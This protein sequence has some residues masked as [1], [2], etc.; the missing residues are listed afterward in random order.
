MLFYFLVFSIVSGDNNFYR[1]LINEAKANISTR[2]LHDFDS[3]EESKS[4]GFYSLDN[5]RVSFRLIKTLTSPKTI[6]IV[7]YSLKEQHLALITTSKS[8]LD[9]NQPVV[10]IEPSSQKLYQLSNSLYSEKNSNSDF[11]SDVFKITPIDVLSVFTDI[12]IE[13]EFRTDFSDDSMSLS[14][15]INVNWD[16]GKDQPHLLS[17]QSIGIGGKIEAVAKVTF[18]FGFI[19]STSLTL[20]FSLSGEVGALL[21]LRSIYNI[22]DIILTNTKKN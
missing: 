15:S 11:S 20:D 10:F 16:D 9:F 2:K 1:A 8:K 14:G 21:I 6:D 3:A 12:E 13:T 19:K 22:D 18:S 4:P 5:G 17:E 7:G